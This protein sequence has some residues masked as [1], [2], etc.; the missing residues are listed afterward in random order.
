[1]TAA[2][3]R[4]M[5]L[6]EFLAWEERQELRYEFDGFQPVAMTG[7]TLAHDDITGNIRSA[8]RSRLRG[9]PCRP[10]GPNVK[11]LAAGRVRYPDVAVTCTPQRPGATIAEAPVIVFEILSSST[12]RT[13]RIEKSREY[14]A[15][16]SIH[17]YVILEQDSIAATVLERSG[18]VWQSTSLTA[19]DTL[20]LPE[21]G[22]S[23]TMSECYEGVELPEP[24][25]D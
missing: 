5:T 1:M 23:L 24:P 8:L 14:L 25:A 9:G 22:I 10:F 2:L 19:E 3:R 21:I 15:V 13:D 12:S 18:T 4:P 20:H 16:E 11:V 17:R 7:G 6:A